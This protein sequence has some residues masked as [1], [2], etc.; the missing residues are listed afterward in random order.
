MGVCIKYELRTDTHLRNV[1]HYLGDRSNPRHAEYE[2]PDPISYG[3]LT[4]ADFADKTLAAIAE[5]NSRRR[6]GRPT[7]NIASLFIDRFADGTA[8]T[9]AEE[10]F[11]ERAV[12]ESVA[13]ETSAIVFRHRNTET[14]SIDFNFLVP[15]VLFE[16][17]PVRTRRTNKKDPLAT[18]KDAS[19]AA[20]ERLNE[21]RRQKGMQLIVQVSD[22][23]KQLARA[24]RGKL[25]EDELRERRGA[26]TTANIK[27]VLEK[28]GHK[29][30]KLDLDR[31]VISIITRGSKE[32]RR[33]SLDDL[34]D[35]GSGISKEISDVASQAADKFERFDTPRD[36]HLRKLAGQSPK[37]ADD[38]RP[39]PL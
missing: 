10:G 30:T 5:I 32:P 15:N 20:V 26:V 34:L 8:L 39:A 3:N 4:V 27:A 33:F 12:I 23:K 31:N 11:H 22:R 25:I 13:A 1:L 21:L 6:H 38:D 24:R 17:F 29:V 18:M 16:S 7:Q 28:L 36:R 37:V 14:L 19:N 2:I 35:A 9:P